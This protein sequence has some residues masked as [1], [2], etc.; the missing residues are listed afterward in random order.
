MSDETPRLDRDFRHL[1]Q[2]RKIGDELTDE[3]HAAA[4]NVVNAYWPKF[5]TPRPLPE[6]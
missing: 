3:D 4:A 1:S 6:R 2:E 5:G